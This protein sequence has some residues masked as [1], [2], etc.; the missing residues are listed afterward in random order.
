MKIF[1]VTVAISEKMPIYA[2]DPPV[3]VESAK[4]LSAGE[5]SNVSRLAFGAHT[6]THV[7]APNHFIDGSRRVDQLD[8]NKLIGQCRVVQV[9]DEVKTIDP[10][11]I[12]DIEGIER[13]LFKT[14]NS[15]YWNESGF[16]SDFAHLSP[17]AADALVAGG[18]KLVGI[19]YL[20]IERF[21]SG[22]HAV[23]KA[24]LSKEIVILE[25]LDL[26]AVEPGDYEL[27]CLPLKYVGGEG[28]GA[29]A[30]AV[31]VQR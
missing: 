15:A 30:R 28:D 16:H 25:G 23:H 6:G 21:H 24:F 2:G 18:V 3:L 20:S 8:L 13:V 22:D 1:D 12:G 14:K 4:Q 5:S 26:R 17:A 29:P 11:H 27:I 9:P 10:E 31:L 7:D 19:D